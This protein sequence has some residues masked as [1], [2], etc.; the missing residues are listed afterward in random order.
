MNRAAAARLAQAVRV[1]ELVARRNA[2][3]LPT[4][5]Y[6]STIRG[7]GYVFEESRQYLRGEPARKIDWNVTAR[8]GKPYVKVHREERQREIFLAVDVSPSMHTGLGERTKLEVAVELAATLAV[9]AVDAGDRLGYAFFA[10]RVVAAGRPRAGRRQLW[11]VLSELLAWTGPWQRPVAVSDPRTAIHAV[12][13]YRGRRFVL[14]LISDLVDHDVPEDLRYLRPRH[15]VSLLH[16]YDPLE[17]GAVAAPAGA[18]PP[19]FAA[20]APEGAARRAHLRPGET[21]DFEAASSALHRRCGELGIAYRALSTQL[22][23]ATSLGLVFHQRRRRGGV[24]G[25][26]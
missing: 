5:D 16:V 4:G 20:Q 3:A 21:S 14:F 17:Q 26:A 23:V 7:E 25:N 19:L 1:L 9:S 18:R 6:L 10:D 22:P 8:L 15:D 2:V 13:A 12:E 11:H 24:R